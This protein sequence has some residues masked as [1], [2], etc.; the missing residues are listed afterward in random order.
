[1]ATASTKPAKK[2]KGQ[3]IRKCVSVRVTIKTNLPLPAGGGEILPIGILYNNPWR[4]ARKR[5]QSRY[6]YFG[7]VFLPGLL[8]ETEKHSKLYHSALLH[9]ITA[10]GRPLCLF[11]CRFSLRLRRKPKN[12]ANYIIPRCSMI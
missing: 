12:M 3:T 11:Q 9:D 1:P 5:R 10:A 4:N 6:T 8:P 2:T 7:A